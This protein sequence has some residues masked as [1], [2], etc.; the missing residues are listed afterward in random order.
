MNP[1]IIRHPLVNLH[2][3]VLVPHFLVPPLNA[4]SRHL[5]D[6]ILSRRLNNCMPVGMPLILK[7]LSLERSRRFRTLRRRIRHCG[8]EFRRV[9]HPLTCGA[10]EDEY[11]KSLT[12]RVHMVGEAAK[13]VVFKILQ[14]EPGIVLIRMRT[15]VVL[16]L[17]DKGL[18]P[19]L[20]D[21]FVL[22]CRW[23]GFHSFTVT[24]DWTPRC[25]V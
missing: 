24:R 10:L 23:R 1:A 19:F 20:E 25:G 6:V 3:L 14:L 16:S 15:L 12:A 8:F 9:V 2:R 13:A 18:L 22:R 21:C 17:G 11:S 7:H 4:A 5:A